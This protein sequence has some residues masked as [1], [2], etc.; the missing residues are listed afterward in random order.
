[1]L[2]TVFHFGHGILNRV[3]PDDW[4]RLQVS[5]SHGHLR[6][7]VA[8]QAPDGSGEQVVHH[9]RLVQQRGERRIGADGGKEFG[10][11]RIAQLLAIIQK[12]CKE[13][14]IHGRTSLTFSSHIPAT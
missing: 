13:L 14:L 2:T 6:M 12:G 5:D 8:T 11:L 1:L 10:E 3:T 7:E 9:K 4:R